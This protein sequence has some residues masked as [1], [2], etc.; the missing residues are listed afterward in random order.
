MTVATAVWVFQSVHAVGLSAWCCLAAI[1]NLQ[2]FRGSQG[3]VGATMSMAPLREAPRIDTPLLA[4]AI[5]S[6]T[7]HRLALL[8]VLLLQLLAAGAGI[9]GSVELIAFG[10]MDAALPW[11][12]IALSSASAFLFTMH[13]G[14]LWFAYWMRQEALQLTHLVLLIWTLATFALFNQ[15]WA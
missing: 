15:G 14:G 9:I 5:A 2:A 6:G 3:A 1:N 4:R 7:V 12:N 8:L 11:L 10:G 13:L